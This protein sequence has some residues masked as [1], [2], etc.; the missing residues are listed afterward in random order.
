MKSL[1]RFSMLLA[2]C[3]YTIEVRAQSIWMD[4]QSRTGADMINIR[5]QRPIN[6]NFDFVPM[7]VSIRSYQYPNPIY[8]RENTRLDRFA[9]RSQRLVLDSFNSRLEMDY[10]PHQAPQRGHTYFAN[11]NHFQR[12]IFASVNCRIW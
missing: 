8:M 3:I 11:Y 12:G 6:N 2:L 4:C 5:V 1:F 10:W 7:E 9:T